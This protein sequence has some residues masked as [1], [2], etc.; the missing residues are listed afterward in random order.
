MYQNSLLTHFIP[1]TIICGRDNFYNWDIL[2]LPLHYQIL[3]TKS[4]SLIQLKNEIVLPLL[5]KG[6]QPP[7]RAL[8]RF[9]QASSLRCVVGSVGL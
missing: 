9:D 5:Y 7:H 1:A 6:S 3:I 4:L 2:T 8:H